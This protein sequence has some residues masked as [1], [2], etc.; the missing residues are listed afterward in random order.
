[1]QCGA[2]GFQ[3]INSLLCLTSAMCLAFFTTAPPGKPVCAVFSLVFFF[4][5][6]LS[7]TVQQQ[8]SA[9]DFTGSVA[10]NTRA[11]WKSLR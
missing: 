8:P 1:M 3:P 10:E 7:L 11:N 9:L 4:F 5:F 6:F 2:G